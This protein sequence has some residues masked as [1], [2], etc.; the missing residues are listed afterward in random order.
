M[1]EIPIPPNVAEVFN[2]SSNGCAIQFIVTENKLSA[3]YAGCNLNRK[4]VGILRPL[5]KNVRSHLSTLG[6]KNSSSI[7]LA[8]STSRPE[9]SWNLV[10]TAEK[11]F[12]DFIKDSTI[13]MLWELN[14]QV[15]QLLRREKSSAATITITGTKESFKI[16][17][18]STPD[19]LA[20]ETI[21][22]IHKLVI[23]GP[24]GS[25]LF[26]LGLSEFYTLKHSEGH[27]ALSQC[28]TIQARA[29]SKT[30]KK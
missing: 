10:I 15:S 7:Q 4:R 30:H 12:N 26:K 28:H 17:Q 16:Q 5:F 24:L 27:T 2:K 29:V 25:Q 22:N 14:W 3:E 23:E 11:R 21:G 6:I 1:Q 13:E 18:D 9:Q 8:F 20:I 19:S